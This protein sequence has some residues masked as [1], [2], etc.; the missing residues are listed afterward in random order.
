MKDNKLK[1][2]VIINLIIFSIV[3]IIFLFSILSFK[4]YTKNNMIYVYNKTNSDINFDILFN[5][6]E[7]NKVE[8]KK[9][10]KNDKQ[11]IPIKGNLVGEGEIKIIINK[12]G[13]NIE[14]IISGYYDLA[15]SQDF[16]VY[17]YEN[18]IKI[19]S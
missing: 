14:K 9:M 2:F 12:N 3:I 4:K 11:E 13:K 6:G 15:F 1:V 8:I 5:G 16:D 18:E 10:E 17:V 7:K 19:K